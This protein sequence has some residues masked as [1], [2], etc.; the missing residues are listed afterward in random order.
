MTRMIDPRWERDLSRRAVVVTLA[1]AP[2]ALATAWRTA[3]AQAT[4]AASPAASEGDATA[5]IVTAANAFLGT[6]SDAEK[7]TGLFAWTDTAQKQR[8]SNFPSG[9]FPRAGLMWGDLSA[10][11]QTALLQVMQATLSA[12]GYRRVL[13][14]WHADDAFAAQ[15]AANPN[16][17]PP[18]GTGPPPGSATPS[19]G[20]RP[21]GGGPQALFGSKYY[22]FALIGQPSATDPWQWQYG[23]HHITINA[24]IV[25]P[26]LALTPS[27]I[28]TQPAL[29]VD[30]TGATIRPLGDIEDDAFALITMLD[31]TQQQAAVLGDSP[32]DLVLGPGQDA[33]TILPQ[34]MPGSQMT[35]E[36]QQAF[37]RL[38]GHYGG[39]GNAADATRRMAEIASTLDQTYL[40]WY[41]PTT[42]G[43]AAY[44][45]VTGPSLVIEY[46]PQSYQPGRG[47]P[48]TQHI[49]GM[50]RDP[51]ND[52]GAKYTGI[53]IGA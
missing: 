29:Y 27:F 47:A 36:Q 7:Q 44:F 39:L 37:V 13:A 8:W 28:G 30:T 49:H 21:A 2:F 23:G 32:I 51:T 19:S 41:G 3:L 4:P 45:R 9:V 52:Y 42:P 48:S 34:G 1:G 38:I 25:G 5:G 17:G 16:S 15:E 35:A 46:A 10:A 40:A 31:A 18:P 11:Q 33:K 22:Y 12:E 20:A 6:L 26:Q 24:T 53:T 50:Y 43:S 14:E